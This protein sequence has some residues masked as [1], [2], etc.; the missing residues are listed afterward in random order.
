[1][2]YSTLITKQVRNAFKY[3]K[4]LAV[5]ITLVQSRPTTFDFNANAN[6]MSSPVT[7]TVKGIITQKVRKGELSNTVDTILLMKSEDISDPNLY[8]TLEIGGVTWN[9]VP[10]YTSDGF[11]ISVRITKES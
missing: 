10:P 3:A 5:D 7:T 2:S 6:T 8:D 4:D 9:V 11:V 1:M